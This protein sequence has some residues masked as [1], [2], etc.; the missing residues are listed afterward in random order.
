M[1]A[2]LLLVF[3]AIIGQRP[4][5]AQEVFCSV[6]ID[7]N[8]VGQGDQQIVQDL[9]MVI[10]EYINNTTWTRDKFSVN[11]RINA[12]M[13]II[14]NQRPT[15]DRF[16]GACNITIRRPVYN[17]NYETILANINDQYFNF[18]YVS[19]QQLVYNENMYTDNL[20]ALL[21]FYTNIILGFDYASFGQGGGDIYFQRARDWVQFAIN[22]PEPG[23]TSTG[24]GQNNRFW[25]ADNLTNSN[26][27]AFR[28]VL[29][30]YH[31]SGLDQAAENLPGARQAIIGSLRKMQRLHRQQP[32]LYII[33]IF[34][35]AKNAELVRVFDRAF[36]ND[37]KAFVEIMQD[38]D[39]ARANEYLKVMQ[40]PSGG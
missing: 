6:S 25:L 30:E 18:N 35:D 31:R 11:E 4:V 28:E 26:Y 27:S 32:L 7:Y 16:V 12:S 36:M 21:N 20:T 1:K 34:L 19:G 9:Q 39:P 37:K 14:V 13:R 15:V 40:S 17:S 23:W 5:A 38:I 33:R 3:A 22:S 29:F 2:L 10:T 8:Q 24:V